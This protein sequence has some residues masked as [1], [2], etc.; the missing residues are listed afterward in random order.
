MF[1]NL[2]YF[3]LEEAFAHSAYQ[4]ENAV[5]DKTLRACM[6]TE[7]R[8]VGFV[9]VRDEGERLVEPEGKQMMICVGEETKVVPKQVLD[10]HVKERARQFEKEKGFKP[11]RKQ[12]RDMK[13]LVLLELLPHAFPKRKTVR[14][15][16]DPVSKRLIVDASSS[17]NA[18][19]VHETLRDVLGSLPVSIPTCENS[20]ACEF[21]KWFRE[22]NAPAPLDL[23][24]D[25]ELVDG[26]KKTVKLVR[27]DLDCTRVLDRVNEGL[28][29]RKIALAV[30]NESCFTLD[31]A[32]RI[33]KFKAIV[34][35][36]VEEG[37]DDS[38]GDPV[39]EFQA[40]MLLFVARANNAIDAVEGAL[41]IVSATNESDGENKGDFEEESMAEAA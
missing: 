5:S 28:L 39:A 24:G 1:K 9:G 7:M 21:A 41:G 16:I 17:K 27:H 22:G 15:L 36:E 40:R 13:D 31:E 30:E 3:N 23:L 14:A 6:D 11:G 18:E 12:L 20:V 35:E 4:L 25:C 26:G 33:T 8:T 10:R 29:P 38:R 19:L 2:I 32:L 34:E 37:G